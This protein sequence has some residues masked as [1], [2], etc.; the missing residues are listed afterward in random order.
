MNSELQSKPNAPEQSILIIDD[1]PAN[2]GILTEYLEEYGFTIFVARDG[3]GGIEKAQY[4]L[5]DLILLDVLM[6][7]IDGFEICRQLKI[8]EA[9]RNIP[10]IFMT[11]LVGPEHAVTGLEVGAVDYITKPF[12]QAEV[13]ARVRTHIALHNMQLQIETQNIQLQQTHNELEQRVKERTAEL[14]EANVNLTAEIEERRRAEKALQQNA[15]R[16]QALNEIAETHREQLRLLSARL[17]E[18]QETERKRLAHEL[19]DRVGQN[20]STLGFILNIVRSQICKGLPDP[21]PSLAHLDDAQELI[22]QTTG[23]VRNVMTDLRPPVLDDF[24]LL[25]ALRWYGQQFSSRIDINITVE[26]EEPEPRLTTQIE[27]GLFR[28]TQEAL[29]NIAKH[30]KATG[31]TITLATEEQAAKLIIV[32]NGIG[33]DPAHLG[34]V[35]ENPGWGLI[36]MTERAEVMGGYCQIESAPGQGTQVVVEVAR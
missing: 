18:T 10:V 5:P 17:A 29:T 32:D 35:D 22:K 36:G 2:L 14:A 4:A 7:G 31:V 30:A 24:G 20:L 16:L 33:F 21:A 6:P 19:H 13:L 26:G 27:N 12:H 9:T 15:E 1:S 3:E 8:N 25:A 23:Y 34:R 11:S 28:I